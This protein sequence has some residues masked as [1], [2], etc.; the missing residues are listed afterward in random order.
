MKMKKLILSVAIL[1]VLN[2]L[3]VHSYASDDTKFISKE[4]AINTALNELSIEVLGIRFD[5]PDS[6]WDVFI[7]SGQH[8]YEVEVDA[9]TGK[10][11]TA[12]KESLE[13]IKAELSG[14]LSHEGVSGDVD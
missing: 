13:E 5:E 8:A 14:D 10:I 11:V 6:Q 4:Q 1:T 3:S 2:S 12:K 9:V 7:K